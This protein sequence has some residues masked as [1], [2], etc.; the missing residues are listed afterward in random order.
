V[1]RKQKNTKLLRLKKIIRRHLKL[2]FIPHAANQYR[3]HLIRRYGLM[4][5]LVLIIGI[6]TVYNLSS[7]GSVL[8]AKA[9]VS[10]QKLLTDTNVERTKN[11]LQLLQLNDQLSQAAFLKA[12]DMFRQQYWAH[13]APDGTSPWHWFSVS[14]YNYAAAGENL[15]KDFTTADGAMAA[16]MSS[17]EHCKNILTANYTDV[18]FAVVDG[19]MSNRKT[20]LIVALYA[21]PIRAGSAVLGT[22]SSTNAPQRQTLGLVA[23]VNIVLQSMTLVILASLLVLVIAISVALMAHVNRQKLPKYLR[24]SWYRHHG[25]VKAGGMLSFMILILLLYSGGQI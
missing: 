15:A 16:W 12:N 19:T 25:L 5:L 20:T 18:G 2:T 24:Q 10:S 14:G 3:P 11:G 4:T 6:Q 21:E 9:P 23:R 17:P 7:A 22:T 8:G 1:K 13:T